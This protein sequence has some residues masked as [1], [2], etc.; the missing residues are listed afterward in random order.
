ML[1]KLNL[2]NESDLIVRLNANDQFA[3]EVLF[4][5]YKN[6]L[7]GFVIKLAPSQVDS[8]EIV[9]KV[10]IKVWVQRTKIDPRKSFSSFL[11][12][13]AKN[14]VIDQ[15]RSSI[16]KRIY[17][18]GHEAI[19]DLNIS[20]QSV[21]ETQLELE[22][23]V[24]ELIKKIPER[25]RQIFELSRYDGLSYKQIAKELNISENT[26]DTQIR[27]SLNYL[28]EELRKIKILLLIFLSK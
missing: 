14:E 28:R 22:Q 25:R 17:F 9:Q 10:F 2:Y 27:K 23:K 3:F 8:D 15:L 6:K 21:N 19:A 13:I 5:K 26:V 12:T 4:Y 1:N 11:F 7:K 24:V 20:D 16:S 18:M